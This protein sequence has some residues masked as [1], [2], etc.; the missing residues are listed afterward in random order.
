MSDLLLFPLPDPTG[1][2]AS[3]AKPADV[4]VNRVNREIAK[5]RYYLHKQIPKDAPFKI[6]ADNRRILTNYAG[7]FDELP[8]GRLR[9]VLGQLIGMG[10]ELRYTALSPD[11]LKALERHK[12]DEEKE[13]LNKEPG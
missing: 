4:V 9:W 2:K 1:K 5:R 11:E 13:K 10:Y 7:H 12:P 8:K 3:K 6:D